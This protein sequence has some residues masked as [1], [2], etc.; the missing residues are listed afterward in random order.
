MILILMGMA[1]L[2]T[3]SSTTTVQ[4]LTQ[5]ILIKMEWTMGSRSLVDSQVQFSQTTTETMTASTS[6]KTVTI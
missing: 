6:M 2:T 5:P 4:C 3:L 1:Y